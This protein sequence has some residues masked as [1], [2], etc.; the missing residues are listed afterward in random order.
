MQKKY[1]S[2]VMEVQAEAR[3]VCRAGGGHIRFVCPDVDARQKRAE[4]AL[5]KWRE[6]QANGEST[7]DFD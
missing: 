4:S 5:H 7:Q 2:L 6:R 1:M 3:K